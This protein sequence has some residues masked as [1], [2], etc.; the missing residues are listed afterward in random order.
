MQDSERNLTSF[1]VGQRVRIKHDPRFVGEFIGNITEIAR[2]S[3]VPSARV[4][5]SW[6]R[7]TE[8]EAVCT[9]RKPRG[10]LCDLL[11]TADIHDVG[12]YSLAGHEYTDLSD[13][14]AQPR[15]T[16]LAEKRCGCAGCVRKRGGGVGHNG[17][18]SAERIGK[19]NA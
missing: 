1:R 10:E 14:I 17:S 3:G 13:G 15:Y 6:Y 19:D 9:Y 16:S 12:T 5:G 11:P 8:I 4:C 2:P 7:F 18:C